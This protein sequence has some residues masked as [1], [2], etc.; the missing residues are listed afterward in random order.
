MCSGGHNQPG[1][2]SAW[3]MLTRMN[4]S[5]YGFHIWCCQ[6][7]QANIAPATPSHTIFHSANI[8]QICFRAVFLKQWF[9]GFQ[10]FEKFYTINA[11]VVCQTKCL[12]IY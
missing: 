6:I 5:S 4:V 2:L 3:T 9:V 7:K 11:K 8:S 12:K 1:N 10:N